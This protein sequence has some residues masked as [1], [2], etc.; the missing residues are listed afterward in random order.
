MA[1]TDDLPRTHVK[2]IVR[3]KLGELATKSSNLPTKDLGLQK[4]ALQAMA[5]SAKIFIHYLTAT[6]NELTHEAKRSTISAEDVLRAVEEADFPQFLPQLQA[7]LEGFKAVHKERKENQS[8]RKRKAVVTGE[9]EGTEGASPM[10]AE[11]DTDAQ[12]PIEDEDE[13]DDM[14]EPEEVEDDEAETEV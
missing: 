11:A 7:S 13:E 14:E 8:S 3:A 9:G 4:D 5:E 12:Q 2:R 10:G 1:D 6:A